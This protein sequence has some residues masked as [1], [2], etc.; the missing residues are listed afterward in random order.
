MSVINNVLRDL[1]ARES[2]FVPLEIDSV[3]QKPAPARDIKPL[4]LVGLLLLALVAVAW[5]TLQNRLL[6]NAAIPMATTTNTLTVLPTGSATAD[7]NL[8]NADMVTDQ[9]IG[10][11]IIGLQIRESEEAMR[12]EFE[13]REKVV[14]YLKQRGE[15]DFGYHLRDV[16]SQIVAPQI[17]DNRWIRKLSILSSGDGV[18]VKFETASDI[19]VETRQNLVEGEPVW[20]IN[21][22]KSVPEIDSREVVEVAVATV[23]P[24]IESQMESEIT[25]PEPPSLTAE[26]AVVE[27]SPTE[28]AVVPVPTVKINIKSTNPNA[29]TSNQLEY[30]VE[31]IN[32]NRIVDAEKLLLGLLTGVED[33]H[34]R[35]HLLVLYNRQ[36]RS[37]RYS[38][39]AR[40]SVIAYPEDALFRTEYARVLFQAEAYRSVIQLFENNSPDDAK[41]QALVAASYQRL[42]EHEAAVSFYQ[43]ALKQDAANAKNWIGLGISQEHTA[44]LEDALSSYQQALDLGTLNTRLQAFVDKRSDTLRQV[45]N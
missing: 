8:S 9:M 13:L 29:K 35:Q 7:D 34:A 21:L 10:N 3:G 12:I 36:N 45:L 20:V 38:Q 41:Q 30:A 33:Y 19:L 40:E 25:L 44:A 14:A 31:L 15:N 24:A 22:R 4:L 2:R 6:P 42:D 43:R 28:V 39:L 18:D 17:S 11:Q 23:P 32:S 16:E 27:S 37:D 1:E 5:V 26:A